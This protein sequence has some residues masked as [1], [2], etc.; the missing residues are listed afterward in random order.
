MSQ[1]VEQ[2]RKADAERQARFRAK[3]RQVAISRMVEMHKQA[4]EQALALLPLPP[5]G[6][7][8]PEADAHWRQEVIYSSFLMILRDE[9]A[10]HPLNPDRL[11]R[12][13]RARLYELLKA[14]VEAGN[15]SANTLAVFPQS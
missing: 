4:A 9:L 2:R 10:K 11:G 3:R 5:E 7:V 12:R 15:M 13:Q 8:S 14:D 6:S 1:T